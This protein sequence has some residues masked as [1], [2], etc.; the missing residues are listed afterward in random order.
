MLA[1][2]IINYIL[3][4]LFCFIFAASHQLFLWPGAQRV[5]LLPVTASL[6]LVLAVNLWLIWQQLGAVLR[7]LFWGLYLRPFPL[8]FQFVSQLMFPLLPHFVICLPAIIYHLSACLSCFYAHV[9]PGLTRLGALTRPEI[10]F[11]W[12]T[13]AGL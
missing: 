3:F 5:Q 13:F 1:F 11:S 8:L 12:N 10:L 9:S 2:V 7:V 4:F 6:K